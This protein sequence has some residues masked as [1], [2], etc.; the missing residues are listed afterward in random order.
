LDE[1]NKKVNVLVGCSGWS[2]EDWVGRFYPVALARKKEEWLRYYASFFSTVEINSTFY[3]PP[4]EFMVNGWIKKGLTLK[5]FEYSVKMPRLVTH[6][7]LVKGM[8]E[9]AGIQASAFEETCVKPMAKNH[10]LGTVLIQMSPYF[11][12]EGTAKRDLKALL[13]A[14]D[15]DKYRYAVEFRNVSWLED[16]TDRLDREA[17][18]M[19][20]ERN[21]ASV[22]VDGPGFP[23]I[24]ESSANHAYVRFH[25]RNFD[26]WYTEEKEDDYRIN[27][28]D[29]LYSEEELEPWASRISELSKRVEKVRVYFNNHGR[30]KGVKNAF[31]I[32]DMLSI[33]HREKEIQVQDQMTLGSFQMY[34]KR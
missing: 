4:N 2:Y 24:K 11:K 23:C 26:I 13:D 30:A 5:D 27:K 15:V 18:E 14:L 31:Q 6:E 19:L 9:A 3:R 32:M 16:S 33:H 28:F 21:V 34:R 7:S 22:L 10:L 8:G 1:I 25:G 12:N 20:K 29:Y 17:F